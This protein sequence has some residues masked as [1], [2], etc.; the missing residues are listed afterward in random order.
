[1]CLME[2][3]LRALLKSGAI[4]REGTP[5]VTADPERLAA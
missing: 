2:A 1:M 3:S 5:C 4:T